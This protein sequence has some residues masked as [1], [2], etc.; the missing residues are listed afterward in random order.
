MK[1]Y[2]K[3]HTNE[4]A[5]FGSGFH[6]YYR[7]HYNDENDVFL[8]PEDMTDVIELENSLS[9]YFCIITSE[10]RKAKEAL[11]LYKNRDVSEKLFRGD[12]SYPGDKSLRVYGDLAA[13]SKI[14]IEFLAHGRKTAPETIDQQIEKAQE[15]VIK[16]KDAYDQ[17]VSSLQKFLD[18][19]DA[20]RKDKLWKAVMESEKSYDEILHM[21]MK[22]CTDKNEKMPHHP[23]NA[24]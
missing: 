8:F 9:G 3:K 15:K 18:I 23:Q 5:Q 17:T 10:H 6:H 2:L 12:K 24:V 20:K 14:F 13:E 19:R 16:A 1:A 22:S 11:L 4:Q 21:I 7:Q